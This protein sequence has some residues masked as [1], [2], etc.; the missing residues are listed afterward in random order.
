M[1]WRRRAKEDPELTGAA[2]VGWFQGLRLKTGPFLAASKTKLSL[3][4]EILSS[5]SSFYC[6]HEHDWR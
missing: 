6:E 4:F 1:G 3:K 5:L 2:A